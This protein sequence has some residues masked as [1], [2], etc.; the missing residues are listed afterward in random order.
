MAAVYGA[1]QLSQTIVGKKTPSGAAAEAQRLAVR[2]GE[3]DA[4]PGQP[5]IDLIATIATAD[6]GPSGLYRTRQSPELIATYLQAARAVGGRLVLDVQPGRSTFI[7][8]TR[9]LAA[10]LAEPD[11]DLALD[12][13]WNVGPKGV[14]GITE[15]KVRS[16]EVDKVSGYLATIVRDNALPQKALYIHQ[17]REGSVRRRGAIA[18]RGGEVAVTLNFDG[19]G[20]PSAK[21]AGYRNLSQPGLYNGFSVFVSR[22]SKVM[23]FRTIAALEPPVDYVMYQ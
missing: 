3:I 7:R 9:A 13:E 23:G 19:I 1:P 11:V 16:R 21:V 2:Y 20:S 12:P 6:R 22:D 18:Q 10:W 14:P 15:G 17:F 8:E 4:R 5:A